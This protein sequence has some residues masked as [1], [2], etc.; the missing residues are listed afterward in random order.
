[1]GA[2]LFETDNIVDALAEYMAGGLLAP[3][4]C[5]YFVPATTGKVLRVS[6]CGKLKLIGPKLTGFNMYVTTGV[7][8]PSG[9]IYFAPYM[10]ENILSISIESDVRL[11]EPE[12][13]GPSCKYSACGVLAPNGSI[14][15]APCS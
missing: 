8:S 2:E 12:L 5:S 11:L 15:F 7:L 4:G 10:A 9:Y 3:N 13:T 6:A 1:M 14:Y